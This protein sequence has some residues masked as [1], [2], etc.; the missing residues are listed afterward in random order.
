VVDRGADDFEF[1]Y[2]CQQT[3]TDWVARAKSLHRKIIMP[4]GRELGLSS[5]LLI[6]IRRLFWV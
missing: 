2:H 4:D 3:T 6:I 5:Y 1:F